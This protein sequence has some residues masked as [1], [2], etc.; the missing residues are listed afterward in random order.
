MVSFQAVLGTIFGIFQLYISEYVKLN[1]CSTTVL[2]ISDL[3]F[4]ANF[5]PGGSEVSGKGYGLLLLA[6]DRKVVAYL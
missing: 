6:L 2:S 4:V 3:Y 1:N 5:I